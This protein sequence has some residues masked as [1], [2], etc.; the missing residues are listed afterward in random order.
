VIATYGR[1]FYIVDDI[2]SLRTM[3]AETMGKAVHLFAPRTTYRFRSAEWPFGDIFEPGLVDGETPPEGADITFWVKQPGAKDSATITI[4]DASGTVVRTMKAPARAGLNR[5]WWDLR[6]EPTAQAKIRVAPLYAPWVRVGADGIPAPG[7]GRY[8]LLQP[9][10]K[11]TVTVAIGG[12]KSSQS[13]TLL[14]DPATAGSDATIAEQMAFEKGVMADINT[15]ADLVNGIEKMRGQIALAK[16]QAGDSAKAR[17]AQ[18]DSMDAKLLKA[19][20]ELRNVRQTG[21]GQDANRA[22]SRIAERL[23]YLVGTVGNS[24]MPPTESAKAV[25]K[26][27]H[28]QLMAAKAQAEAVMKPEIIM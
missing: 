5:A 19:E 27:L 21:R 4:A 1:G 8:A 15:T 14:K 17:V 9:P 18:L 13:F 28:D 7:F 22:P 24:D 10:G 3:N 2:S 25:A 12:E 11:Y 26:E 6:G 23:F 16:A 20:S